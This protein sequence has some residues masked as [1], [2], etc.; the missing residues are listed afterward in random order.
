MTGAVQFRDPRDSW[1]AYL[2]L[3]G[4]ETGPSSRETIKVWFP[5]GKAARVKQWISQLSYGTPL[6]GDQ[7]L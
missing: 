1:L 3:N 7:A 2:A 6:R 5:A 4:I